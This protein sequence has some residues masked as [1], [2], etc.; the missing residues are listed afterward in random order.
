MEKNEKHPTVEEAPFCINCKSANTVYMGDAWYECAD[1][2][3]S[4]KIPVGGENPIKG[5][6]EGTG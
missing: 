6:K 1:C 5:V 4:F 2:G 3:Q